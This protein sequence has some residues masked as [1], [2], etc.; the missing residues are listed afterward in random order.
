MVNGKMDTWKCEHRYLY[1]SGG[2]DFVTTRQIILRPPIGRIMV[3]IRLRLVAGHR[4]LL[5]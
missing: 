3:L 1:M 5:L 2:V 4:V